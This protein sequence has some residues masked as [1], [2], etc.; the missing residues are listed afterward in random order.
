MIPCHQGHVTF[1]QKYAKGVNDITTGVTVP[2]GSCYLYITYAKG[3]NDITTGATVPGGGGIMLP[4]HKKLKELKA[5]LQVPSC[6]A[7]FT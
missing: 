2:G 7:K 6:Q 5:E 3:V 4:L 1:T